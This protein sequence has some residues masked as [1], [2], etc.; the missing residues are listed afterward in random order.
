MP[1]AV[2]TRAREGLPWS[3]ARWLL[4]GLLLA[5][6]LGMHVLSGHDSSG[7]HGLIVNAGAGAHQAQPQP[8]PADA[9]VPTVPNDLPGSIA[10]CLLA[11]AVVVGL[12]L[13]LLRPVRRA[14]QGPG[15]F[16]SGFAWRGPPSSGSFRLSLCVSR[17]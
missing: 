9:M 10:A 5:G 7:R 17:I 3:A 4:I 6:V 1:P 15:R 12:A 11:L 14:R 8:A 13:L 16:S 2:Q